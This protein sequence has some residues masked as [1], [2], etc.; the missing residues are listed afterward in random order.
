MKRIASLLVV[1]AAVGATVLIA[2]LG[3]TAH[4]KSCGTFTKKEASEI[5]GFEVVRTKEISEPSTGTEG[6]D[7]YTNKYWSK[8]LKRLGAPYKLRITVQPLTDDVAEALDQLESD[9]D[10]ETVDGVGDRAF[11]TDG[12]D[13]VAVSG[14]TVFQTKATNVVWKNQGLDTYLKEPE[15]AAMKQLIERTG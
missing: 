3:G 8:R 14:D 7:Y 13:L 4:A 2:P 12:N 9:P 15:L 6:C 1:A 11:Y 10:A 5:L